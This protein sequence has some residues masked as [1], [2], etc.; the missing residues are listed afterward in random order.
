M[1]QIPSPSFRLKLAVLLLVPLAAV[2]LLG[3]FGVWVRY[4][5]AQEMSG[6][7]RLVDLSREVGSVVHDLQKERGR[8]AGY[9][10]FRGSQFGP[11]LAVQQATTDE[12]LIH[13]RRFLGVHATADRR[14]LG[15]GGSRSL[16]QALV[17]LERLQAVRDMVAGQSINCAEAIAYYTDLNRNLLDVVS[18]M[19]KLAYDGKVTN[20][21]SAYSAFL[22]LKE[23]T[24]IE[25]AVLVN[26]FAR[27][28]FAPGMFIQFAELLGAETA[29]EHKF[30]CTA[31]PE[32][33]GLLPPVPDR[34]SC[35]SS[36][37]IRKPR[38]GSS[39]ARG[40]WSR[41]GPMV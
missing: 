5:R 9:L 20:A 12:Q 35:R 22:H 39:Y 38:S 37:R 31:S 40:F 26:A 32:D 15:E 29:Y 3:G 41:G 16:Q 13:F 25:R 7:N 27:D 28:T 11:E 19:P 14:D 34:T 1:I 33:L 18:A 24:G 17:S 6:V 4:D 2:A 30:D 21:F 36:R 10:G 8:T 23:S